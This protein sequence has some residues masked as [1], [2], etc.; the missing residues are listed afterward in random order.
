MTFRTH[1]RYFTKQNKYLI[2]NRILDFIPDYYIANI[3]CSSKVN[4]TQKN[5]L[6]C[7]FN[8]RFH[9]YRDTPVSSQSINTCLSTRACLSL[10]TH[11]IIDCTCACHRKFY[12]YCTK[13]TTTANNIVILNLL[14]L[15]AVLW[16]QEA[17]HPPE[18][19]WQ[20]HCHISF[21]SG[22]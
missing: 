20:R 3:N 13:T 9:T 18:R 15:P 8:C 16:V 19:K 1:W 22:T 7:G 21:V 11:T 12:K 10:G 4:P 6:N 14:F 17:L 2:S 5:I